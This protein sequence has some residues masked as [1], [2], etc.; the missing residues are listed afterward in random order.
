MKL[1]L[2]NLLT[3]LRRFR[4]A[5]TLNILGLSVAFAAFTIIL[6]QVSYDRSFDR[7]HP[8]S[9]RIYRVEVSEDSTTYNA[10]VGRKWAELIENRLPQIE[11]IGLRMEYGT[12]GNLAKVERNGAV[13]GYRVDAHLIHPDFTEI[14]DFDMVEGRRE[15]LQEPGQV[16]IPES[17]AR[18]FF[19]SESAVGRSITFTSN[20][21]TLMTVGG[22][23]RDFPRNTLV[24]NVVY[25]GIDPLAW[26][27]WDGWHFNYQLYVTLAEG[28]DPKEVERQLL[29]EVL[30]SPD[31]PG[32]IRAYKAVRLHPLADLHYAADTQ[33]D[34]VPK[35]SR[36]T[37]SVLLT[38]ALLVI[39]IAAV[40]FVN[41]ATSLVPL[42]IKSINTQKVFGSSVGMLRTVLVGEAVGIAL[43]AFLVS[44]FWVYVIGQTGFTAFFDAELNLATEPNIVA[45]SFAVALGVGLLAGL[46][47]AFYA[48]RF[49]PALV[50]KGSF[51][52]SLR[53]RALRTVLV[54]MQYVISTGL[55]IAAFFMQLQNG[56]LRARDTGYNT[57]QVAVLELNEALTRENRTRLVNRLKESPQIEHVAFSQFLF[58]T[59]G[60][61]ANETK[62]GG[63]TLRFAYL[64]VSPEFLDVMRIPV[65]EGRDFQENDLT[66]DRMHFIMN[67]AAR[68]MYPV[69]EPGLDLGGYGE[70][71][72]IMPDINY[73]PLQLTSSGAFCLSVE[74][75]RARYV[76]TLPWTY[77]WINGDV[78]RAVEHIRRT[79]AEFDPTYPVSVQFYDEV[80][81][82]VYQKE[83]KTTALIT[84]F[85]L[86]A[87]V[88][89]LVGVFGLVV[90]ETQYR[91]KEIGVRKVLGATVA[92]VLGMFNRSF[93]RLVLICFVVAVPLAWYGVTRWLEGFAYRTPV[94][95]WV[96][97]VSLL[98]VLTITL[99]TVTVQSWRAATANPVDALK[100]E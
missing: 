91:R 93:V 82:S 5:S 60:A 96:F 68:R 3:V 35:G 41:F 57:E 30:H 89:S 22:V 34:S 61:Q 39:G 49:P 56:Y 69:I 86:L 77:V 88:I 43:L 64:P 81:N 44:L 40:N 31:I 70:V 52:L 90:F 17:M 84:T 45:I 24:Q 97:A 66:S 37:T 63:E 59:G 11:A 73:Q 54:G 33:Y 21:D 16:L 65:T 4:L 100:T 1:I 36:A 26:W 75:L 14:F 19:G 2:R 67:E 87:V 94:Y 62:L 47:P 79:V 7:F 13:Q 27:P 6:I 15:V 83:R 72:G 55:I 98:I 95:W 9:D 23:Y 20:H 28:S 53:G 78:E 32:W 85:S 58:G 51:G 99:A 76:S 71:V 46:Y 25:N 42:R 80:F 50:L 29:N 92:E 10:L 38:I 18:K 74:P 8:K 12:I 48:T